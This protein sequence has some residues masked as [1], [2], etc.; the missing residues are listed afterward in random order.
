MKKLTSY[1]A[2]MALAALSFTFSSCEQ[3]DNDE[4]MTL[5][6]EWQG[7]MHVA[8]EYDNT[9]YD[10]FNTVMRFDYNQYSY[11]SGTGYEIDYYNNSFWGRDYVAY[12]FYWSVKN[13]NIYIHYNE[14]NS[15]V[16]IYDYNLDYNYFEGTIKSNNQ[17]VYFQ[18][19]KTSSQ[20]DW[21]TYDYGWDYNNPYDGYYYSKSSL[22]SGE[23]KVPYAAGAKPKRTFRDFLKSNR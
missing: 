7:D 12:S 19:T 4:A 16:V 2:I 23:V 20:Y 11:A 21:D 5:A 9:E 14:D 3:D 10:A 18:L 13:G 8:M 6:G 17:N 15:D 22:G 1:L